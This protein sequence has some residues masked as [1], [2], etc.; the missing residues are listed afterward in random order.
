MCLRNMFLS[1]YFKANM[2]ISNFDFLYYVDGNLYS[3]YIDHYFVELSLL[4]LT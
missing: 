4:M 1:F 2:E 3:L